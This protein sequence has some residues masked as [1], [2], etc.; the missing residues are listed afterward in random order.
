MDHLATD[1][2]DDVAHAIGDLNVVYLAP[3]L[4]VHAVTLGDKPG[5]ERSRL[6]EDDIRRRGHGGSAPGPYGCV[7]NGGV[8]EEE[9]QAAVPRAVPV[10]VV[11]LQDH[12][13]N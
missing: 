10:R 12:L 13:D 8:G 6:R 3:A 2:R 9:D 5:P 4:P 1:E 11:A 7:G